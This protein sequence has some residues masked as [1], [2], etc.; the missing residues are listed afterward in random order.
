MHMREKERERKKKWGGGRITRGK[1]V[2]AAL[3]YIYILLLSTGHVE[4][5][6][7]MR[8]EDQ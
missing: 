1:K 7:G 8:D 5:H 3:R 6:F 4:M 2:R